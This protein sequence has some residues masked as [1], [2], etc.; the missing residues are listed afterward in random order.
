[1]HV[2]FQGANRYEELY[3]EAGEEFAAGY[4]FAD[5]DD[6]NYEEPGWTQATARR[7]NSRDAGENKGKGKHQGGKGNGKDYNKGKEFGKGN[8]NDRGNSNT[9]KGEAQSARGS[10]PWRGY[11]DDLYE[12]VR[13]A[14]RADG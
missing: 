13:A 6:Y 4:E 1:M 11:W 10:S 7:S 5:E 8:N 9:G 14:A 12:M 2:D 3:E